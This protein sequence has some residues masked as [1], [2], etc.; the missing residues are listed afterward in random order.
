MECAVCC[1]SFTPVARKQITCF[2]CDFACC[3]KCTQ[4]Y[5]L[6]Q[7]T[8]AHCMNC[9]REWSRQF[10]DTTLTKSFLQGSFKTR[11]KNIL[12]DREKAMLPATQPYAE[13]AQSK[14]HIKAQLQQVSLALSNAKQAIKQTTKRSLS[15]EVWEFTQQ[16]Y[17]LKQSLRHIDGILAGTR[18]LDGEFHVSSRAVRACPKEG[19]KGFLNRKFE[20]GLCSSK[21]CNKCHTLMHE[22]ENHVCDPRD[23][24]T[25]KM[26]AKETKAC[27]RC[28]APCFKVDGC[29][30]VFAV[31][32]GT[33]FKWST[34]TIDHGPIHAPDY[35]RWLRDQGKQVPRNPLDVPCGADTLPN[36]YELQNRLLDIGLYDVVNE[37]MSLHRLILHVRHVEQPIY[38][39]NERV[40]VMNRDLRIRYMLED[41][42]TEDK[43]KMLLAKRDK[44]RSLKKEIYDVFTT[45]AQVGTDII[46][47]VHATALED[48]KAARTAFQEA[49]Q[50]RVY[51]NDTFQ[52]IQTRYGCK[53]IPTVSE[54]WRV[55]K[56]DDD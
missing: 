8:A 36:V 11:Q 29:D 25:A 1:C 5:L 13:L 54:T 28:G 43:F 6:D 53:N 41:D 12:F 20:C 19:C 3:I 24:E 4:R 21:C 49:R 26:L 17:E 34:G 37:A 55:M 30:Q 42:M 38:N 33:T 46:L 50:L 51:S 7:T 10:L 45:L 16:R 40:D 48:T 44:A 27:P 22:V 14:P 31:C 47:R 18:E 15:G 23:I 39:V 2:A 32:C 56:R 9:K 52:Q 35:Y